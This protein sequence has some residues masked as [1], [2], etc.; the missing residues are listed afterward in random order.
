MVQPQF[1]APGSGDGIGDSAGMRMLL[2]VGRSFWAILAGYFG[3]FAVLIFPAP[4]ALL[5]GILAVRDIRRNKDRH[6]MGR[7]IFGIVMGLI[8]S[9]FLVFVVVVQ[10]TG[11]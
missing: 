6:G 2:P 10:L 5:F 9:G 3:L 8:G 1:S 4:L 11:R 7:A